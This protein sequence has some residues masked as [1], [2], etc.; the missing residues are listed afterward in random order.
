M[1]VPK[2]GKRKKDNQK[3]TKKKTEN[4]KSNKKTEDT[5][6]RC[7]DRNKYVDDEFK[8][9]KELMNIKNLVSLR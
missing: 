8:C 5:T 9:L 6:D 4:K 2:R 3:Q 7:D 1:G